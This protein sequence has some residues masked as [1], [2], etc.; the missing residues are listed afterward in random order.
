M[1]STFSINSI[2]FDNVM[3]FRVLQISRAAFG[4][5]L[6]SLPLALT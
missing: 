3:P 1:V 4:E 6:S 2:A 5:M